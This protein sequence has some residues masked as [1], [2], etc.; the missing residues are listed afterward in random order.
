MMMPDSEMHS[1][2]SIKPSGDIFYSKGYVLCFEANIYRLHDTS[3]VGDSK[4]IAT[5]LC[6][7]SNTPTLVYEV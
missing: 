6:L 3:H 5:K 2:V 1:S 4:I 7:S